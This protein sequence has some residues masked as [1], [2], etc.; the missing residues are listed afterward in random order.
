MPRQRN[1]N[2]NS[3]LG[4]SVDNPLREQHPYSEVYFNSPSIFGRNPNLKP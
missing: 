2:L 1:L 3:K 4:V